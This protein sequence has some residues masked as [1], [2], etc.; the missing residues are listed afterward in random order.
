MTQRRQIWLIMAIAACTVAIAAI[1][2]SQYTGQPQAAPQPTTH[3]VPTPS[4]TSSQSLRDQLTAA[5]YHLDHPRQYFSGNANRTVT[6]EFWARAQ[7]PTSV[8]LSDDT[9]RQAG[10]FGVNSI[11]YGGTD[12]SGRLSCLPKDPTSTALTAL[13]ADAAA[14]QKSLNAD[15]KPGTYSTSLVA[16]TL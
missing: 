4:P 2:L 3:S 11:V 9:S 14:I 10:A 7:E 6:D 1:V 8:I 16:C 12:G 5:G 15:S 13:L